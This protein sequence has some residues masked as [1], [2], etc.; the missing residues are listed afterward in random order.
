MRFGGVLLSVVVS[1]ALI[2][3]LPVPPALLGGRQEVGEDLKYDIE[4]ELEVSI[5][6]DTP[7]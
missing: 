7:H 1:A 2:N 3:A 4:I 6:M 5:G